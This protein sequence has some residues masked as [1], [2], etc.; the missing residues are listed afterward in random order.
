MST[1]KKIKQST[2]LL[3]ALSFGLGGTIPLAE[4]FLNPAPVV[5]QTTQFPDVAGNYWANGFITELVNRGIIA[6]FPDGSFRPDAPV[7]RAQFAAMVQ[8]ALSKSRD[9]NAISFVDVPANY[10]AFDAINNAYEMGFLSGYP[11]QVFRPEQNIPREQV[12]VALANGL[13]YSA[14][15]NVN[16]TLAYYQDA[17]NIADFARGPIAAATEKKMVVNYSNLQQ[18][19]PKR[20]ATRAEVAALIYQALFSQGQ[21]QALNSP[22][23]VSQDVVAVDYRITAGTVIPINYTADKILLTRD[24][25]V[26][27]TLTVDANIVNTQGVVLIPQGSAIEGEFRPAGNGTRFVAQRLVLPSGQSYNI[28]AT[29]RVI[30]DTESVSRGTDF[31]DLLRN[32]A[33]GT[34][35]AAAI[36]AITGDRAIATE[37]LLIGAGAGILA[38]LIPQFLGLNRVDLLVVETNTDL[39]LTLNND[40][41]LQVNP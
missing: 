23:I 30:T 12:L 21:V 16:T 34:G 9:R 39:D 31:G 28:N 6:G 25:V 36:A 4:S 26:P 27:V 20:N 1:T 29:S 8:K 15:N 41:I 37:E 2:A 3:L 22:Y 10:W 18:L 24:E 7:T 11:G 5:A 17:A 14:R 19:N 13:N 33:L 40:L 32:A 35:A 38:T